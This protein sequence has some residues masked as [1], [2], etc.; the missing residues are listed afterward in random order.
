M[1]VSVIIPTCNRKSIVLKTITVAVENLAKITSNYEIIVINDGQD[2]ILYEHPFVKVYKNT[3]KGVASARN[4]GVSLSAYKNLLFLDD[5]MLLTHNATSCYLNFFNDTAKSTQHCLNIQRKFP[6]ELVKQCKKNNFGRFLIHI[7]YID[8]KGWMKDATWMDSDEFVVLHLASYGLAITNENFTKVGGYNE[9]FPFSGFEDY[10]F[11]IRVKKAG[12]KVLFNTQHEIYHNEE[13]QIE[14]K[15]WLQRRYREGATR[16]VYVKL[17]GDRSMTI[18]PTF[19]K[20]FA[21][22]LIYKTQKIFLF[23][24]KILGV[25]RMFDFISFALYNALAGAYIWKGYHE[26]SKKN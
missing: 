16:A 19:F 8:M 21:F 1:E 14:P 10:D 18:H 9:N 22:S 25:L 6:E 7:N 20:R 3:K 5:D 26:Y 13:D 15:G 4:Y 11:S 17:T 24:T 2:D 23:K 12:I